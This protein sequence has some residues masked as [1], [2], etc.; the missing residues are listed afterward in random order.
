MSPLSPLQPGP[1]PTPSGE[2]RPGPTPDDASMQALAE[3][4]RSSSIIIRLVFIALAAA[5]VISCFRTVDPQEK[6]IVLRLGRPVGTDE[7]ALLGPGPHFV[8]PYPVDELVR[9]PV[10]EAQTVSSTVGW[11]ATTPALEAARNEP[12]PGPTLNPSTDGYLM[13]GDGSVV[14][15][16]GTLRY[17]IQEPGISYMLE[18]ARGSNLVR[19]VLNNAMVHAAARSTVEVTRDPTAYREKV[20]E[21]LNQLIAVQKLGVTVDQLS[22]QVI[23]PRQLTADFARVAEAEVRRTTALSEARQYESETLSRARSGATA[24]VNSAQAERRRLVESVA[25]EAKRFADI[26]PEYRKNP[27]I[28]ADLRLAEAMQRISTNVTDKVVLQDRT[29]G[30]QRELRLLLNREPA[31]PKEIQRPAP[32]EHNH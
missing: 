20:A 22:V 9:I 17:R 25:A 2:R 26:L 19:N 6:A 16:R 23:A 5:L 1:E 27:R 14:H 10:G 13:T 24:R 21:R 32:D 31:K 11:Y 15:A 30:R 18:F 4:L 7:Q 29:D 12:P 28:Y 3:A 8:F